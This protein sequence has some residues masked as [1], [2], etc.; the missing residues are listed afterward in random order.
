MLLKTTCKIYK[1]RDFAKKIIN[2]GDYF[3]RV[4]VTL[5]RVSIFFG[6][7]SESKAL[8]LLT[9]RTRTIFEND[10]NFD[11]NFH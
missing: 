6:L 10:Q 2:E 8:T 4:G 9:L 5:N 11:G 7:N 1:C 3:P